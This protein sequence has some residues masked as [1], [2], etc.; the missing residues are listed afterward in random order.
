M[1]I[2]SRLGEITTLQTAEQ[3]AADGES[4][5]LSSASQALIEISGSFSGL[6]ANFEGFMDGSIWFAAVMLKQD[7]QTNVT[8]STTTGFFRLTGAYG[9]SHLRV[10]TSGSTGAAGMTVQGRAWLG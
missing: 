10:R 8:T 5:D 9:L 1:P 3:A 4:L 7:S 2:A 6:T